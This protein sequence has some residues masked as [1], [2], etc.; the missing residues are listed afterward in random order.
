VS[1]GVAA[2]GLVD[3]SPPGRYSEISIMPR[4][5][6]L[7]LGAGVLLITTLG[8]VALPLAGD[9]HTGPDL[10]CAED[11]WVDTGHHSTTQIEG[12]HP[13]VGHDHCAVCHLQRAMGGAVDDAKRYV[14]ADGAMAAILFVEADGTR[15]SDRR[16][17][18]SRAP[19]ARL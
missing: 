9:L 15:D 4:A 13:S 1:P 12:V 16:G 18:P 6:A 14:I 17:L 8:G 3:G 7:R 10:A 2:P 19:P 11:A 5:M